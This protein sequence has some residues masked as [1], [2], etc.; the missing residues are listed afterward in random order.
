VPDSPACWICEGAT[1]PDAALAPLPFVRC[2]ACGFVFRPELAEHAHE[3]YEGGDYEDVRGAHYA[4][5]AET[6]DR[7][8]DAQVRLAFV[9]EHAGAPGG[10]LLDVG[11]AGGNF[12][13]AAARAGYRARGVEPVPAFAAFARDTTGA[14]VSDGT[15]EDLDL[16][17]GS[18]DVV[19]MWHVLEHIPRPVG[20][21]RRIRAALRSGGLLTIEVPNA[22]GVA[23]RSDGK[24]WGSLEPD[25]HVNQFAPATLRLA[26]EQAGFRVGLIDTVPVT[27]YLPA[28]GRRSPAHVSSR[29]KVALLGRAPRAHHPSAHEL[30]RAIAWA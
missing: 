1:A 21:L 12:T 14:D 27:P 9:A 22:G 29:L 17:P 19:T 24:A 7:D 18:L 25:V 4:G 13:A 6:A 15:L 5:A 26:L 30:L 16:P 10:D 2:T 28:T 11:A 3:V 8:R 23:A 20:E